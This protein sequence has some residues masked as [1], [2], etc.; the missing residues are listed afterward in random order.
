MKMLCP[1][2]AKKMDRSRQQTDSKADRMATRGR[3]QSKR[4]ITVRDENRKFAGVI[5]N[6]QTADGDELHWRKQGDDA[7]VLL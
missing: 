7:L 3:K 2:I 5:W 1:L 6:R 4:R